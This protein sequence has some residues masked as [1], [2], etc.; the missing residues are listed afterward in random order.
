MATSA[1]MSYA[2]ARA[3]EFGRARREDGATGWARSANWTQIVGKL[4]PGGAPLPPP[5]RKDRA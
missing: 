1:A 5:C 2:R 4:T 3:S